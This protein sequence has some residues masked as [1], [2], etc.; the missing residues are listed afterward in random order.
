MAGI[1]FMVMVTVMYIGQLYNNYYVMANDGEIRVTMKG[2]L[3]YEK[4][5]ERLM[6]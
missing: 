5:L 4:Q 3:Y 6:P 1:N 2:V